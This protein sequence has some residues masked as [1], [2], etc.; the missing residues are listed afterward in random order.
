VKSIQDN[1]FQDCTSLS[2]INLPISI[3]S[4]G[5]NAFER[6]A[7]LRTV[8][9]PAACATIGTAA[10]R[11]CSSLTRL[12]LPA[13]MKKIGGNAFAKCVSLRELAMRCPLPPSISHSTFKGVTLNACKITVPR[14]CLDNYTEDKSWKK[15]PILLD[16]E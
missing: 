13:A 4:I 7:S 6:C 16:Q 8:I 2:S 3:T 15:M 14:G 1:A 11:E 5:D 12:E 10:F 9:V